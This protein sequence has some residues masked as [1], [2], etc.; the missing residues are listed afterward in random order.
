MKKKEI[1]YIV[2]N[3]TNGHIHTRTKSSLKAV[4]TLLTHKMS[5]EDTRIIYE[6]IGYRQVNKI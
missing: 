1:H 4:A 6:I 5:G 3:H 2:L